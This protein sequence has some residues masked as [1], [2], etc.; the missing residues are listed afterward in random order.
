MAGMFEG[1][2]ALV[3]GAASGNGQEIARQ[4]ASEGATV[5]V[6]ARNEDRAAATLDIIQKA[7]GSAFAAP[8]DLMDE[9]QIETMCKGAIDRMGGI[10]I[11]INNAGVIDRSPVRD[12]SLD[13][14]NWIV[15]SNLT[16]GFLVS[17]YTNPAVIE[18][19]QSTGYGRYVFI[20]SLSGKFADANES[21]YCTSK[22]AVITFAKCMAAELGE[23]GIT[24][25]TVCPGWF[26][27]DMAQNVIGK[28]AKET[29]DDFDSLYQNV[30]AGNMLGRILTPED[31]ANTA[32]YL[33]S[34]K[35][36]N[37]T[38]QEINVCGGLC[39]W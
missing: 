11:V 17:K 6:H 32:L 19:A 27:T 24:V 23:F 9:G 4:L 8:A 3:T 26:A 22:A 7:G 37:I 14:W 28:M 5:A 16:A 2:R 21:A 29:G 10:E 38:A 20:S 1:K 25:N 30:M 13:T 35:A 15:G 18:A 36:R 33:C 31:M 34:E 12:M 39:Y